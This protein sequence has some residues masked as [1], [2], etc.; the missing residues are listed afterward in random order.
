MK[1]KCMENEQ[2]LSAVTQL[3]EEQKQY[4]AQHEK[5]N[6]ALQNID[7]HIGELKSSLKNIKGVSPESGI[8]KLQG[9]V[10]QV[11]TQLSEMPKNIIQQR[12]YLLFPEYNA[13]E[14]YS[15]VLKWLLYMLIATYAC[16]LLRG[17]IESL[18]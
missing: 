2:I 9:D 16:Y 3:L 6:I 8:E 5:I 11:K 17:L 13:K 15:A 4:A 18:G 10:A 12:R 1:M 14:Y 7:S